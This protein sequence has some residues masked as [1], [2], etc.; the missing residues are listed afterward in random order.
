MSKSPN[1][2]R[3][4]AHLSRQRSGAGQQLYG[5]DDVPMDPM[6]EHFVHAE[7]LRQLR[8]QLSKTSDGL[9]QKEILSQIREIEEEIEGKPQ[10]I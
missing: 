2:T 4:A 8:Q 3:L 7:K 1:P 5:D 6:S 9:K 10:K